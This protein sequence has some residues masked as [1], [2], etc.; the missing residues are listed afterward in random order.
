MSRYLEV[1]A[2][3]RAITIESDETYDMVMPIYPMGVQESLTVAAP[4]V[5]LN[6]YLTDLDATAQGV[7]ATLA[8]GAVNGQMKCIQASVVSGGTTNVTL[9]SAESASL[10]VI[11]F[12]VI[13]DRVLLCWFDQDDDGAGYWKILAR[14][15]TDGDLDT[16]TVG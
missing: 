11:T 15:D 13:G 7:A 16:P 12:T 8:D 3:G 2:D 9:A 10:D 4:A 5:S 1:G 14:S 6:C